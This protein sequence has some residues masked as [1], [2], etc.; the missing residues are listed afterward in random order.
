[1]AQQYQPLGLPMP[2]AA[3]ASE[4]TL[5]FAARVLT[6]LV[7]SASLLWC[8]CRRRLGAFGYSGRARRTGPLTTRQRRAL[9]KHAAGSAEH[10]EAL[11]AADTAEPPHPALECLSAYAGACVPRPLCE[12]LVTRWCGRTG[13]CALL[14]RAYCRV[15][16]CGCLMLAL[17]LALGLLGAALRYLELDIAAGG[18][19]V[20]GFKLQ[21][22]PVFARPTTRAAAAAMDL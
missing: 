22:P 4:T 16:A 1:M 20:P 3:A 6:P 7:L 14:A 13:C 8:L 17:G 19:P 18:P 21:P 11:L 15:L 5:S 10:A 2:A 12:P 9:A